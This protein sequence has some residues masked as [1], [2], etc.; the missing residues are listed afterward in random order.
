VFPPTTS[1]ALDGYTV[2]RS[3]LM[4]IFPEIKGDS[5][6]TVIVFWT[7]MLSKISRSEIKTVYKNL[8]KFGRLNDVEVYLINDD[9]TMTKSLKEVE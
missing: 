5:D 2:T 4:S 8:K 6:Y 1:V 3:Q 7:N 9:T